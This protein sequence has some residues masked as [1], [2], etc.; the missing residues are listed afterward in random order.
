MYKFKGADGEFLMGVPARDL[1]DDEVEAFGPDQKSIFEA[2]MKSERPVYEHREDVKDGAD[3][4]SKAA[5]K[6]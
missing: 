4:G 2:H 6:G 1:N 5:R 3:A